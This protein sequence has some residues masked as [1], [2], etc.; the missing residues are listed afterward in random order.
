[1]P[2]GRRSWVEALKLA[3]ISDIHG[4]LQAL[5]ATLRDI[6]LQSADTLVVLGDIA[7]LG[8]NPKEVIETLC[9]Y[10]A[11]FIKGNHDEL[12]VDLY[13]NKRG[14]SSHVAYQ[15]AA[16]KL[17]KDHVEFLKSFKSLFVLPL[18]SNMKLISYHASPWDNTISIMERVGTIE[19]R[20]AFDAYD[21]D[22]FVGGHEHRQFKVRHGDKEIVCVGSAG[23]P[24]EEGT[25]SGFPRA[26]AWSEYAIVEVKGGAIE[27]DFRKVEYD[28]RA[29]HDAATCSGNPIKEWL[30]N[31]TNQRTR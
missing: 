21:G 22:I 4:N 27:V 19:G 24:Y 15:W 29:F 8:P 25:F 7:T 26:C 23:F 12:L 13:E 14:V 31:I 10:D 18:N 20:K 17:T 30:L 9:D 5:E 3:F 6:N 1:M 16:N 28:K 11:L 2:N